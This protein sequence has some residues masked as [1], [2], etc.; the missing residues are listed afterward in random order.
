[1]LNNL[2]LSK[3]VNNMD[4][5]SVRQL[6]SSPKNV[7][8]KLKQQGQIVLTN[9][10]QPIALMLE[11]NGANLQEKIALLEQLE[12]MQAVN[13]MQLESVRNGNCNL[14]LDEINQEIAAA[15]QD[16]GKQAEI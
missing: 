8:G 7:W 11:V 2:A 6:R 1:M 4:Y 5:L 13:Q 9:N 15:R 14:S 3:Q 10:G 12:V 16:R